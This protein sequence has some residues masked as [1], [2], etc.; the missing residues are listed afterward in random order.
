MFRVEGEE[1]WGWAGS[2]KPQ[3]DRLGGGISGEQV[4]G[5]SHPLRTHQAQ[6][7]PSSDNVTASA[8]PDLLA[9]PPP[10]GSCN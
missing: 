5:G 3:H 2:Q 7:M 9:S 1:V 10:R 8:S 4:P 6:L